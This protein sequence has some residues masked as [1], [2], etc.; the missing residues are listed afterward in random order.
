MIYNLPS[1]QKH[2]SEFDKQNNVTGENAMRKYSAPLILLI[3]MLLISA[4]QPSDKMI[5]EAIIKTQT[6]QPNPTNEPTP[7]KEP[8]ATLTPDFVTAIIDDNL[9]NYFPTEED[10]A[11]KGYSSW[12]SDSEAEELEL[13]PETVDFGGVAS[14]SKTFENNEPNSNGEWVLCNITLFKTADSAKM[15]WQFFE[16]QILENVT[17]NKDLNIGESSLTLTSTD[18]DIAFLRFL[19]KNS[20]VSVYMI[21]SINLEIAETFALIIFNDLQTVRLVNPS[22]ASFANFVYV[23]PTIDYLTTMKPYGFYLVGSE[24]QPGVWRNTGES[25]NCYWEITDSKGEI[26]DNYIGMTGGTMYIPTTAFQVQLEKE[27]GDWEYL[28]EP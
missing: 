20:I 14:F 4:C 6:A 9:L 8:T 25:D 24:I 5:Q 28:G 27:C 15:E 18:S 11:E 19:Y 7:T 26:I 1:K 23:E 13:D 12:L 17:V 10:I 21:G 2:F 16:S 3:T 22:E